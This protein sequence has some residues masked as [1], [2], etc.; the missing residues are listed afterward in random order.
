[1]HLVG[2]TRA[3]TVKEQLAMSNPRSGF[4]DPSEVEDVPAGLH[5]RASDG[6]P[7]PRRPAIRART[8]AHAG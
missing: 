4:I 5:R 6:T 3:E 2:G 8:R 7:R 1:V